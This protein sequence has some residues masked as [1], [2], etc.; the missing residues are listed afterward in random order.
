[1][2]IPAMAGSLRRTQK[3]ASFL[4]ISQALHPDIFEQPVKNFLNSRIEFLD[5][6]EPSQE[7][8]M[9]L[10]TAHTWSPYIAGAII[11]LLNCVAIVVSDKFIGC[12]TAFSCSSGMLEKLLRGASAL[13]R[14]YYK[15]FT[16]EIDWVWMLVAGVAV[17]AF[18]SAW[19]SGGLQAVWM[20][21][22]WAQTFGDSALLRFVAAFAGG[23]L[24]ALGARWAGGCTS[25][26]GISGTMQLAVSSW[27]AALCFFAGGIATAM[28]L[29]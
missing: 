16:P 27:V 25:G 1:M 11:G 19:L 20:P 17:G 18:L 15:K 14:P 9:E 2:L 6:C 3:Y 13:E 22:L 24:V 12:S 29:Y 23:L 4:M 28:L 21:G 5:C 8:A 26:H 10:F 7:E